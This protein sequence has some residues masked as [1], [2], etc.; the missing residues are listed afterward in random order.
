[1]Y[2]LGRTDKDRNRKQTQKIQPSKRYPE[3]GRDILRRVEQ[4]RIAP[5]HPGMGRR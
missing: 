1:M 2:R 3:T 4:F 5:K